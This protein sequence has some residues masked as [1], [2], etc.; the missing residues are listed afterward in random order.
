MDAYLLRKILAHLEFNNVWKWRE[1]SKWCKKEIED[2][3][4]QFIEN[5]TLEVCSEE[6]DFSLFPKEKLV[7]KCV[8]YDREKNI[9]K[10]E[11]D[12]SNSDNNLQ[13]NNFNSL[14][15]SS[16][17]SLNDT[18]PKFLK[19]WEKYCRCSISFSVNNK[20]TRSYYTLAVQNSP[21][22]KASYHIWY[23]TDT[24]YYGLRTRL[25][26]YDFFLDYYR[27]MDIFKELIACGYVRTQSTQSKLALMQE[28]VQRIIKELKLHEQPIE[29]CPIYINA[30]P[31][32]L[33]PQLR[34]K[35]CVFPDRLQALET[36]VEVP[37]DS[38][39]I[40]SAS[41]VKWLASQSSSA[42]PSSL[43]PRAQ[44]AKLRQTKLVN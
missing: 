4:Q 43:A 42:G 14:S 10:F 27:S 8:W 11:L 6:D 23:K 16:V 41:V 25:A 24:V 34:N 28:D 17:P 38:Y 33:F 13:R 7:F 36:S 35:V 21:V 20:L 32:F 44:V 2:S 39:G 40:K 26:D 9:F 30:T 19:F 22:R 18:I 5:I 15:K 29:E 31:S 1:L 37:N 3:H 12:A